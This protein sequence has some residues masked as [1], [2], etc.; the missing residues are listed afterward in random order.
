MH[1]VRVLMRA[2]CLKTLDRQDNIMGPATKSAEGAASAIAK[3]SERHGED[4]SSEDEDD[5][6]GAVCI[7]VHVIEGVEGN[8]PEDR[9]DPGHAQLVEL[10]EP[11]AQLHTRAHV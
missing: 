9:Y 7:R 10:V 3:H 6:D 8:V 1:D 11:Y 5:D 2:A 4:G